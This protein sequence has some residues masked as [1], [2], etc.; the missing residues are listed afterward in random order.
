MDSWEEEDKKNEE[1]VH[2][3]PIAFES[4][5]IQLRMT[6]VED[7]KQGLSAKKVQKKND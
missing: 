2:Y 6:P 4:R 3:F 5:T 1:P 7:N